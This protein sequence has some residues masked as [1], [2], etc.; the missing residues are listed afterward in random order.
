MRMLLAFIA[1]ARSASRLAMRLTLT[2]GAGTTSNWVTTGPVVRPPIRLCTP[3]ERSFSTRTSPSCESFSSMRKGSFGSGASSRSIDGS[4]P[5]AGSSSDCSPATSS[6]AGPSSVPVAADSV[7]DSGDAWPAGSGTA[8]PSP[9]SSTTPSSTSATSSGM[10]RSVPRRAA[11]PR[12]SPSLRAHTRGRRANLPRRSIA[13]HADL[14]ARPSQRSGFQ[15]RVAT[16]SPIRK[17]ASSNVVPSQPMI[18]LS[19][20][21]RV[22]PSHPAPLALPSSEA[23][24]DATTA[25]PAVRIAARTVVRVV[26]HAPARSPPSARRTGSANAAAPSAP[27]AASRNRAPSRPIAFPEGNHAWARAPRT[28]TGKS[29]RSRN[30][31][32]TTRDRARMSDF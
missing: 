27:V 3:N 4:A 26:V 8:A 12:S 14:S 2:P 18:E 22:D 29:A 1:S 21:A 32:R 9:S 24:Q 7:A 30:S 5:S 20:P 10:P 6:G 13:A 25:R 15:S 19:P 11:F 28:D 16:S 31:A 23:T 17:P